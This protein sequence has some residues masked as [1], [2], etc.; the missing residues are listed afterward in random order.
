MA[1]KFL[2]SSQ[3]TSTLFIIVND[4]ED[5]ISAADNESTGVSYNNA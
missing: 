3:K 2:W 1:C 5:S 4:K